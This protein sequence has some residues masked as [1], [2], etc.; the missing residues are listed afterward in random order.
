MSLQLR[1]PSVAQGDVQTRLTRLQSDLYQL[2]E[3]LNWALD[4]GLPQAQA[5]T[6]AGAV[7][8]GTAASPTP[9][10][11]FSGI[12]GLILKSADIAE[13]YSEV[14]RQQLDGQYVAQSDFGEYRQ[15]TAL[16]LEA[17][18]RG[19]RQNYENL[20]KLTG[21][22][23]AGL[24]TNA[25]LRSGLLEER[26]DGTPVYGLEV[27]QRDRTDGTEVFHKFARFTANRLEF[28]DGGNQQEPVAYISDYRLFITN[29]Q[30]AGTLTL[31]SYRLD[32][33][34]G[35]SIRWTEG[36]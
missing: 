17:D 21:L 35:L 9:E 12:K 6:A 7:T 11:T 8:A 33:A 24:E 2:V 25:Y 16:L 1:L 23:N 31:G 36:E 3:Q 5:Q 27:G 20:Q 4:T 34:D 14:I 13:A 28:Y 22:V 29:A 30:I 18:S 10:E 15:D 26:A 19:I 32:T